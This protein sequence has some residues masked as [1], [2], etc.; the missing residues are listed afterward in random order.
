MVHDLALLQRLADIE[1]EIAADLY[2]GLE[3]ER[4]RIRQPMASK[5]VTA[6]YG[7]HLARTAM[8]AAIAS[9]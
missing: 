4:S 6:G 5:T 1:H 2:V 8:P 3:H 9:R 7:N